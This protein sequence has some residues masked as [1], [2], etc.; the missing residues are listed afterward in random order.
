MWP[1]ILLRAGFATR[2]LVGLSNNPMALG[3]SAPLVVPTL[4]RPESCAVG[5][6]ESLMKKILIIEDQ[7]PMR[8]NIALMLEMEGF[9]VVTAENG[10]D[11]I[12][13]ARQTRP[14]VIICDVMMPELDGYGVVQALRAEKE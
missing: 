10:R 13:K 12:E 2:T 1:C 4:L 14:D 3:F 8:R 9:E 11:G 7:T 5:R 6:N